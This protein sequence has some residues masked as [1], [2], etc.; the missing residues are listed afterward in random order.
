MKVSTVHITPHRLESNKLSS[1]LLQISEPGYSI[2]ALSVSWFS[3]GYHAYADIFKASPAEKWAKLYCVVCDCCI[4]NPTESYET[5]LARIWASCLVRKEEG[6]AKL[7]CKTCIPAISKLLSMHR[8]TEHDEYFGNGHTLMRFLRELELIGLKPPY[9]DLV[10][11]TTLEHRSAL[12]RLLEIR[13][14]LSQT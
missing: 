13:K 5:C 8:F 3:S 6:T 7:A 12:L 14:T 10:L 1:V 4:Y 11:P 2:A 9:E